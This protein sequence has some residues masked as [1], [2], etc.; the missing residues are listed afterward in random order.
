MEEKRPT[1]IVGQDAEWAAA[2]QTVGAGVGAARLGLCCTECR[3]E[4]SWRR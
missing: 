2:G 1:M 4:A 3:D